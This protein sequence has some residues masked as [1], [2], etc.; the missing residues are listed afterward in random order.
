MSENKISNIMKQQ[1][2]TAIYRNKRIGNIHT[3]PNTKQYRPSNKLNNLTKEQRN[4]EIWSI[5]F[6]EEKIENKK[7]YTC[8]IVS[9]N[10]RMIVGHST[11]TKNT[12][13]HAVSTI[14]EAVSKYGPP[15]MISSDRGSPFTSKL[16]YDTLKMLGITQSMSRPR[17]AVD[18]RYIETVFKSMK[19]ELGKTSHLKKEEYIRVVSYWVHYYNTK[20]LHSSL[21]YITP[22]EKFLRSI[23]DPEELYIET[24]KILT[25]SEFSTNSLSVR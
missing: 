23:N 24:R 15:S 25:E 8:A 4:Q 6:T 3:S 18:N 11:T 22:L 1:G 7:L 12:S 19:I 10:T 20:R 17:K 16:Y 5:D 2:L 13:Q 14:I 21:G 9:I